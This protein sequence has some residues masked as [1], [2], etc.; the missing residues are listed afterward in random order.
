MLE[1]QVALV[2]KWTA[3]QDSVTGLDLFINEIEAYKIYQSEFPDHPNMPRNKLCA[4]VAACTAASPF[5]PVSDKRP[6]KGYKIESRQD[7][8]A[9]RRYINTYRKL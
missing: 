6:K 9:A 4:G 2:E 1:Q 5:A 3:D 7:V 8:V